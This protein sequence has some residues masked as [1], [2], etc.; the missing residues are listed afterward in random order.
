[1]ANFLGTFQE[2]HDFIGPQIRNKVNNLTRSSRK[3][4]MVCARNVI[5]KL[6]CNP[7]TKMAENEG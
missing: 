6:N 4:Q 7:L 3:K 2:F 1:M 5:K